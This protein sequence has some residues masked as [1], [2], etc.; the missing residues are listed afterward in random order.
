MLQTLMQYVRTDA[1]KSVALVLV[2]VFASQFQQWLSKRQERKRAIRRAVADLLEVRFHVVGVERIFKELRQFGEIPPQLYP[3]FRLFIDSLLPNWEELHRRY[4]E[5][6]TVVAGFDPILGYQLRS[7]DAIWPAMQRLHTMIPND[8]QALAVAPLVSQTLTAQ[9]EKPLNDA[10]LKVSRKCGWITW[11]RVRRTLTS[12]QFESAVK[13]IADS[14][15]PF[16]AAQANTAATAQAG[17]TATAQGAAT[18]SS[19]S[20]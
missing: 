19:S 2:G 20:R 8:P 15:K 9:L 11:F 16:A 17:A 1:F 12:E 3:Q 4:D 10:I 6:V 13:T 7:K 18:T 5:S 14:L